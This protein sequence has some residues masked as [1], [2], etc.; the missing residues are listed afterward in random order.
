[1][2]ERYHYQVKKLWGIEKDVAEQEWASPLLSGLSTPEDTQ[3]SNSS[4]IHVP[5][6][7]FFVFR[8]YTK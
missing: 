8:E 5:Q 2:V 6:R 1:M 3:G 4:L 7:T